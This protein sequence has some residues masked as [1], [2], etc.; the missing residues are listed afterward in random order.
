MSEIYFEDLHAQERKCQ[1]MMPLVEAVQ[2]ALATIV[3]R[4]KREQKRLASRAVEEE[5]EMA[6]EMRI[7][8][9]NVKEN[10]E[11]VG[12]EAERVQ[13]DIK[14]AQKVADREHDKINK[15]LESLRGETAFEKAGK[16]KEFEEYT[17]AQRA[18][19]EAF[20]KN[21]EAQKEKDKEA[22]VTRVATKKMEIEKDEEEQV[23]E[24]NAELK[25][26]EE[27]AG[28]ERKELE[29]AET[30]LR[31]GQ[32][33]A[34]EAGN[35]L[36]AAIKEHN[37]LLALH[38]EM[39]NKVTPQEEA[40]A[41][42]RAGRIR[43]FKAS[44]DGFK[45]HKMDAL[46]E[47]ESDRK[48][49]EAELHKKRQKVHQDRIDKLRPL[50]ERKT[51]LEEERLAKV[52]QERSKEKDIGDIKGEK[53]TLEEA[54]RKAEEKYAE[55]KTK[56][57]GKY[58]LEEGHIKQK[59]EEK[60]K[61]IEGRELAVEQELLGDINTLETKLEQ[62]S[63]AMNLKRKAK[64]DEL[65]SKFKEW[66]HTFDQEYKPKFDDYTLAKG[67]VEGIKGEIAGEKDAIK[68]MENRMSE[69]V[70]EI[71][72]ER[73]QTIE[74]IELRIVREQTLLTKADEAV[75]SQKQVINYAISGHEMRRKELKDLMAER[76]GKIEAEFVEQRERADDLAKKQVADLEATSAELLET[77]EAD[78]A[79]LVKQEKELA[80]KNK[81]E[82]ATIGTILEVVDEFESVL[83]SETKRIE[84]GRETLD[85]EEET[86]A[87]KLR[88]EEADLLREKDANLAAQAKAREAAVLAMEPE[89][90]RL[91]AVVQSAQA[92]VQAWAE[93]N[94]KEYDKSMVE[95]KKVDLSKQGVEKNITSQGEV[96]KTQLEAAKKEA[97][98]LVP[99]K[100]G[101]LFDKANKLRVAGVELCLAPV[102]AKTP[103]HGLESQ[104]KLLV[105]GN[106]WRREE[107]AFQ[108]KSY[109]KLRA[110]IRVQKEIKAKALD[111]ICKLQVAEIEE[112]F[113]E[114]L[115][116]F[117]K[118][119]LEI[120][121]VLKHKKAQ[122]AEAE[123]MLD[124][125]KTKVQP[126][127][128]L[129][130]QK[131]ESLAS[132][133]QKEERAVL[134]Q[135]RQIEVEVERERR[136]LANSVEGVKL[137][138]S[139]TISQINIAETDRMDEVRQL[140]VDMTSLKDEQNK[141]L[142]GLRALLEEKEQEQAKVLKV[143]KSLD[144]QKRRAIEGADAEKAR[145][146]EK[147]EDKKAEMEKGIEEIEGRLLTAQG[148]LDHASGAKRVKD[149]E[150]E[151]EQAKLKAAV[152]AVMLEGADEE[153]ALK[154][155]KAKVASKLEEER[156]SFSSERDGVKSHMEE[157]MASLGKQKDAALKILEEYRTEYAS[158]KDKANKV[159]VFYDTEI[160]EFQT[161]RETRLN[162]EDGKFKELDDAESDIVKAAEEEL[163]TAARDYKRKLGDL[164]DKRKRKMED[165]EREKAELSKANDEA[166]DKENAR[167][168]EIKKLRTETDNVGR[169]VK[170]GKKAREQK[171]VKHEEAL[172]A[173]SAT[174]KGLELIKLDW[175]RAQNLFDMEKRNA[176]DDLAHLNRTVEKEKKDLE[177][178]F[179][180][181][182]QRLE[183]TTASNISRKRVEVEKNVAAKK[184]ETDAYEQEA[185][186]RL[187]GAEKDL[188]EILA[189]ADAQLQRGITEA[190]ENSTERI[191]RKKR[192]QVEDAEIRKKAR[193]KSAKMSE[194]R[195]MRFE[196]EVE[197]MLV[198]TIALRKSLESSMTVQQQDLMKVR[199]M[200]RA[201]ME[202]TNR[203]MV[204][205]E[206]LR[207]QQQAHAAA[208]AQR[209]KMIEELE[210][211]RIEAEREAARRQAELMQELERQKEETLRAIEEQ[212]IAMKQKMEQEYKESQARI[213]EEMERLEK[214]RL[215]GV[216]LAFESSRSS[217]PTLGPMKALDL[218]DIV[219]QSNLTPTKVKLPPASKPVKFS[220]PFKKVA[221]KIV[222]DNS[223][224]GMLKKLKEQKAAEQAA[225]EAEKLKMQQELAQMEAE[226]ADLSS[227]DEDEP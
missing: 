119:R 54:A 77:L 56:L 117:K 35:E 107:E 169:K 72:V 6:E 156:A 12:K 160:S 79:V 190:Q 104:G 88:Q 112:N 174:K 167:E 196:V 138:L 213:K 41:S 13:V 217:I 53:D 226:L 154:A 122:H 210:R 152:D 149:D 114:K 8:E 144:E 142:N 58:A 216:A 28:L 181:E 49:V 113:E 18:E 105:L 125:L 93:G 63:H 85:A 173:L 97:K 140:E 161:E 101:P 151:A 225:Y 44:M 82:N 73:N 168:A 186:E 145:I 94:A 20:I 171:Q 143:I 99:G 76:T 198:D 131:E 121:A 133:G 103:L 159:N 177:A 224:A 91:D 110:R 205:N 135:I 165:L 43:G 65:E 192:A 4:D 218:D 80:E 162:Y 123:K 42:E 3:D 179:Q 130:K 31:M 68:G 29:K 208:E 2:K 134:K 81:G 124:K 90:R 45:R 175:R 222:V 74:D 193:A 78:K 26:H 182:L 191:R 10:R 67:K 87:E 86:T 95:L 158:L 17:A 212:R 25:V 118:R 102:E 109:E 166:I 227:S 164:E 163:N 116:L 84:F 215:A 62:L 1:K 207:L 21:S 178:D 137:K 157:R 170:D 219:T 7:S 27:K 146:A 64:A 111:D 199:E 221:R 180:E 214:E 15:E 195:A 52:L 30:S 172:A 194:D 200:E 187:R 69:A 155:E 57:E 33:T 24:R 55:E 70:S 40:L 19:L 203:R 71:L 51:Q 153:E 197:N 176:A 61:E 5:E 185:N 223:A 16:L 188:F 60:M 147:V 108:R 59:E 96:L 220:N 46:K 37:E 120:L 132:E 66:K 50:D 206:A 34:Q 148:E 23:R 98:R 211:N 22:E 83:E 127:L 100:Y 75:G 106:E 11:M 139:T 32:D 92:R 14:R 115:A 126:E 189:D 183:D 184:A 136:K 36:Q 39:E 204:E 38:R 89:M 128:E 141:T 150:L 201:R 202:A 129:L 9:Q 48:V 47:I 209:L